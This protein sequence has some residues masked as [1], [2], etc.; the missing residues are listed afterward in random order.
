MSGP[1]AYYDRETRTCY[2]LH[3]HSR[4]VARAI[5]TLFQER[6]SKTPPAARIPFLS[7]RLL[8]AGVI[9]GALHD[10]GKASR[11]YQE[12][13][14]SGS[15][16]GFWLHEYI[17]S[18]ILAEAASTLIMRDKRPEAAV[19]LLA[20]GAVARHHAAMR[21]RHPTILLG[22]HPIA[23]IAGGHRARHR[24]AGETVRN[25]LIQIQR[26]A[27][28]LDPEEALNAA[29]LSL[30]P[31]WARGPIEEAIRIVPNMAGEEI[32]QTLRT[33]IPATALAE[34]IAGSKHTS[35]LITTENPPR[36]RQAV[37]SHLYRLSGALIVSDILVAGCERRP[38]EGPERAYAKS[39]MRELAPA[40]QSC[41]LL[42]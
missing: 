40:L 41:N 35:P 11:H 14:Q 18:L 15:P 21:N 9:A 26:A 33:S 17:G 29:P 42:C 5:G 16:G 36:T 7:G 3:E 8:E 2:P 38:G 19:L 28:R 4:N 23:T 22:G 20:A 24:G 1:C 34:R 10:I 39:W 12:R 32:I 31:D 25:A 27:A 6:L 30:V 13:L 37:I